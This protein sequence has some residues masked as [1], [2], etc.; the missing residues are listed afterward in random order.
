MKQVLTTVVACCGLWCGVTLASD[1][2]SQYFADAYQECDK[3]Y[4]AD[5]AAPATS[6]Q[7]SKEACYA[8]QARIAFADYSEQRDSYFAAALKAAPEYAGQ[9]FDAALEAGFDHYQAVT[10]ATAA[11]PKAEATY[12]QR[13]I[14]YGADPARVTEA[15]AAG[16][17]KR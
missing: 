8:W 6:G 14:S 7:F 17:K 1:P 13:A 12:A 9:T 3:L 16:Y 4:Q 11:Y 5:K 15:T 2:A 10:V